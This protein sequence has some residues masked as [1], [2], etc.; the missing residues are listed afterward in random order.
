MTLKVHEIYI[1]C[2]VKIWTL[3]YFCFFVQVQDSH[4]TQE[5]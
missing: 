4:K 3:S 5:F 2:S 1:F